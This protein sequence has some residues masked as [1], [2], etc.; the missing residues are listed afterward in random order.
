MSSWGAEALC[1]NIARIGSPVHPSTIQLN[2]RTV[3]E[4]EDGEEGPEMGR[5]RADE[6]GLQVRPGQRDGG[7]SATNARRLSFDADM[8]AMLCRIRSARNRH[9]AARAGFWPSQATGLT[10]SMIADST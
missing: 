9:Q 10:A 3:G 5:P 7:D 1:P 6:G 4:S 8:L 2:G